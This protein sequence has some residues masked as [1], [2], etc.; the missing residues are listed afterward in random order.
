MPIKRNEFLQAIS[1]EHHHT[2]LLCWK[3][4][5]G[6]RKEIDPI[7]IKTYVNWFY[8]NFILPHFEVEEKHIFP[9][10]GNDH[11][12]VQQ[13]LNEHKTLIK[14]FEAETDIVENL[15]RIEKELDA[16]VRF[17][18][19]ILFNEI[20]EVA[21][22]EQLQHIQIVHTEEPFV[23]NMEDPFWLK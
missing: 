9:L 4:K 8:K 16:H 7:R 23:D 10:L 18:E 17:E 3:I 1:R 21:S 2:L 20:Q 11:E 13:A 19:R 15:K 12:M 6:F 5:T 14:I 22:D